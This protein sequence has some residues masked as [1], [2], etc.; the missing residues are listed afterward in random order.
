[1][2]EQI[3]SQLTKIPPD[4]FDD[5]SIVSKP[6]TTTADFREWNSFNHISLIVAAEVKFK[7]ELNPVELESLR[8]VAT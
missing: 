4:L 2:T 1:M 5:D 7:V 6:E 8:N 3:Y